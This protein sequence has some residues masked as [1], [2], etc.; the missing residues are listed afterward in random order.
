[1]KI[2][3]SKYPAD[4][5]LKRLRRFVTTRFGRKTD[6]TGDTPQQDSEHSKAREK[7]DQG[8]PVI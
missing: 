8:K 3:D 2:S 4:S 6:E 7:A 5:S 1:M